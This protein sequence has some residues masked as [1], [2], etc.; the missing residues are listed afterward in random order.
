MLNLSFRSKL[1]AA[2]ALVV[3]GVTGAT[4]LVTRQKVEAAYRAIF[5]EQFQTQFQFF[6][7]LQ[8]TRLGAVQENCLTFVNSVRLIAAMNEFVQEKDL[9]TAK[10]LYDNARNELSKPGSGGGSVR[11]PSFFRFLDASG[12]V[13]T[14][15][16]ADAGLYQVAGA[17]NLEEQLALLSA[18]MRKQAQQQVGYL[19]PINSK[20]VPLLHEVVFTRIIDP[21]EHLPL[22]AMVLGYAA[23]EMNGPESGA[24]KT[25][26]GILLG[27]KL[28][29][30]TLPEASATAIAEL[31]GR[32]LEQFARNEGYPLAINGEPHWVI[33]REL[34]PGSSFPPAFQVCAFSL[35]DSLK[36]QRELLWRILLF[37]GLALLGALGLS[38]FLSHGLS[39][40]LR[41]L[42]RATHEIEE[43]NYAI[44]VP[45]RSSDEVGQLAQ[46]FN[47]MATGLA[48]K[49]RY[50]SVLDLVA[51]K[52]I[53]EDLMSGKIA[54]GGEERDVSVLF[55][56]IRGFTA[57]T[58]NMEPPE[59]IHMLNEHFTP[60]T[61]V[62]Y[63]HHGVVDKFVGDLIMGIFGA[64]TSSGNDS[65]NAARCALQMIKARENLSLTSK[66]K[67]QVGIGIVSGK[68]LAG[69][70]GSSDRLNYTVLGPRVNLA[71]RLCSQAGR[72]EVVIDAETYERNRDVMQVTALPEMKL[73]GFSETVRAYQLISIR[74]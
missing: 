4:L 74:V 28:H 7:Q 19:A 10:D 40:P 46:S 62:I 9:S 37:G 26:T 42:A 43:G 69:R 52:R 48:L 61:R 21:V 27:K 68:A 22:G 60:L 64:P 44:S 33:A 36:Q 23:P 70:M 25:K 24:T 53:A 55:C 30:T 1:L 59:V 3:I 12:K 32:E 8:D 67:I 45:V 72:M 63:E 39:V 20:G 57:L 66:Y 18:A 16:D 6:T 14:P 49:E 2:M 13:I 58:Q 31:H 17:G 51:D 41:E 50:R 38:Y 56:D 47:Q 54:L 34:N 65:L 29:S 5:R 73:K 35:A 71:S 11:Q 15:P